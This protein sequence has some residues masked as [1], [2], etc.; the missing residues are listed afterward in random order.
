MIKKSNES[1][2]GEAIQ[3]LIN[4]F[5]L[6]EKL[7]EVGVLKAWEPVVGKMIAKRTKR[8]YIKRGK[9]FVK[10]ESAVIVNELKYA[11]KKIIQSLN[12]EAGQKIIED[13][14]FI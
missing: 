1:T 13:I 2:I 10:I 8:I 5:H 4:T 9:L 6:E 12:K 7:N 3:Q 11:R 14:I